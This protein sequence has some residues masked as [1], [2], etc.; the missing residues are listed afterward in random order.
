MLPK[1]P[2]KNADAIIEWVEG[3]KWV[4]DFKYMAGNGSNIK[5]RLSNANEQAD[6]AI[7]KMIEE[8]DK[9]QVEHISDKFMTEHHE[10]KGIIIYDNKDNLIY[11][12]L[13]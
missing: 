11:K 9:S 10:F 8:I 13:I 3:K 2:K 7:I 4:V 6:Y 1:Y 12:Q 5:R